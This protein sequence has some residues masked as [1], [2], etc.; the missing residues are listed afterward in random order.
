M[1][2][3]RWIFISVLALTLTAA[4]SAW[5]ADT[6]P[7]R[8]VLMGD[9]RVRDSVVF[10][11]HGQVPNDKVVLDADGRTLHTH[12]P[13]SK[14]QI[15][16]ESSID[17]SDSTHP[18]TVCTR[19]H[20]ETLPA[21]D[22]TTPVDYTTTIC[23]NEH[24]DYSDSTHPKKTCL[25]WRTVERAYPFDYRVEVFTPWDYRK[26]APRYELRTG[27]PHVGGVGNLNVHS[28]A[29]IGPSLGMKVGPVD[30]PILAPQ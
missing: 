12:I 9:M 17:Y 28:P 30:G 20:V 18:K 26:E 19:S 8:I 21:R 2:R 5:G 6:T 1:N 27:S 22:L 16:D 10:P 13:A 25:E 3:P 11:G 7:G 29:S 14:V 23:A 24:V 4:V 15:C